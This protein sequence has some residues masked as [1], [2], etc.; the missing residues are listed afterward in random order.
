[1]INYI[2]KFKVDASQP[3]IYTNSKIYLF[4]FIFIK[5]SLKNRDFQEIQ[6]NIKA[7]SEKI[8]YYII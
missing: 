5:I 7:K 6:K 1:M 4:K 3:F 2:Y 8:V